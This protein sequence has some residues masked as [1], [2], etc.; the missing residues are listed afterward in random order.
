MLYYVILCYF[1]LY[2]VILCY[3]MLYYVILC[4][5]MLYYVLLCYIM[6]VCGG[7]VIIRS[8]PNLIIQVVDRALDEVQRGIETPH[9]RD[10]QRML[11]LI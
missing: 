5:Y 2:Y 11:V 3:F 4:Y 6:L 8:F 1:M 9:R 10:P 7:V